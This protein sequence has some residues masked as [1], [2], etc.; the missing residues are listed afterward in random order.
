M[1]NK[2]QELTQK[3]YN[4]GVEK[5]NQEAEKIL[6]DAKK[7]AEKIKSEAQKEAEKKIKDAEKKADE[8]KRNVESELSLA[9]KQ[10]IRNVEQKI[11]D[12]IV[13]KATD[14]PVKD[15]FN[16]SEFMKELIHTAVKNWSPS[17]E[18]MNLAVLLPEKMQK[19]FDD[20][21]KSKA[22]KELK[23]EIE[24]DFSESI[25]GGFKIGPADGSFQ[26]SFTQED[27]ANFFKAYLRPK[28]VEMLYQGE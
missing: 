22:G 2:L 24:L 10:T 5:A 16:D 21:F 13:A 26:I 18:S 27:F 11:T 19:D 9:A 7:E 3:L 8:I 15:A 4:E 14:L 17:D 12:M 28:T 6:N 20:Y 1:E 25:K 23:D